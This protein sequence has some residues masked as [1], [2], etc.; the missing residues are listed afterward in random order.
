MFDLTDGK[1][2]AV[3]QGAVANILRQMAP[4]LPEQIDEIGR[5]VAHYRDQLAAMQVQ[6]A[7]ILATLKRLEHAGTDRST[8]HR[9]EGGPGRPEKSEPGHGGPVEERGQSDNGRELPGYA[10]GHGAT[11]Q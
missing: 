9:R 1:M 6:Q 3:M 10:A 5:I 8:E 7:E 4:N 2:S 11:D